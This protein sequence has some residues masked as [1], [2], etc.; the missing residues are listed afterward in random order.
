MQPLLR[1]ALRN[2]ARIMACVVS[3][4]RQGRAPLRRA[5]ASGCVTRGLRLARRRAPRT[6]ESSHPLQAL[7]TLLTRTI[8]RTHVHLAPRRVPPMLLAKQALTRC[9]LFAQTA[10][11]AD[12]RS[13]PTLARRGFDG[14]CRI[15]VGR[16][17]ERLET[18]LSS[19]N[20]RQSSL[21]PSR[22]P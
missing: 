19:T 9:R 14:H 1:R 10:I 15:E 20:T 22:P 16:S 21:G 6:N 18:K 12:S 7:V 3:L 17:P 13:N 5:R 8:A 2:T 11:Y 4:L